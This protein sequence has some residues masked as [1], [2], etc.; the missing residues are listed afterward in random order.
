[1]KSSEYAK[2]LLLEGSLHSKLVPPPKDLEWDCS[3]PI[4]I[5]K[6]NRESKILWSEKKSKIPRLEH[7]NQA[8]LRGETLHHFANHELMA[9]EL[10]AWAILAFPKVQLDLRKDWLRTLIEEQRHLRL[11]MKRMGDLGIEL[12]ERPLNYLFWKQIPWVETEL[13][14]TSLVSLSLEGAN[15][16]F[17]QIYSRAFAFYGDSESESVTLQVY[18]DEIKH[19]KRGWLHFSS[20][21]SNDMSDWDFFRSQLVFPFT[22]RRAK[23]YNFFPE[24]RREVGCSENFIS[25]LGDYS[26]KYS[27]QWKQNQLDVILDLPYL[28]D[29]RNRLKELVKGE[30]IV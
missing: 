26:D 3:E 30:G 2:Y 8:R 10:F 9:I 16:D 24:T 25:N 1:M 19:V 7:L 15:L 18:C 20:Q 17:M 21:V 12:G 14:F 29:P 13:Q 28:N 5:E 4:R 6:P 27:N 23:A 22:P 11:Y